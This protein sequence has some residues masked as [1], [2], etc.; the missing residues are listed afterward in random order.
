MP[1]PCHGVFGKDEIRLSPTS[2]DF[3][4][5]FAS[6]CRSKPKCLTFP[7]IPLYLSLSLYFVYSSLIYFHCTL[8]ISPTPARPLSSPRLLSGPPGGRAS[9]LKTC[10]YHLLITAALVTIS[11]V[12]TAITNTKYPQTWRE[13]RN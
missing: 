9:S 8:L 1:T 3:C 10:S 2:L 6:R 5:S 13:N 12:T 7:D 4:D 11:R